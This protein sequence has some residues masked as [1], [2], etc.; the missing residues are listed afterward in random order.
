M[1]FRHAP[2]NQNQ[3]NRLDFEQSILR[4]IFA[5]LTPPAF[6]EGT[7]VGK[8]IVVPLFNHRNVGHIQYDWLIWLR[9]FIDIRWRVV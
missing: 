9:S 6:D 2:D 5:R 3:R 4:V 7:T 8:E 1:R